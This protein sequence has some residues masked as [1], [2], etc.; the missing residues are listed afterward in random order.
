MFRQIRLAYVRSQ[1][2][3]LRDTLD[4][5]TIVLILLIALHLPTFY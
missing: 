3:L 4:A 2:T 5:V 1:N